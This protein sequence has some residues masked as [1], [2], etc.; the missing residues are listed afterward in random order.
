MPC[1]Q[2][3][4]LRWLDTIFQTT[5]KVPVLCATEWL[6]RMDHTLTLAQEVHYQ[7]S[8][9]T[10]QNMFTKCLCK[11]NSQSLSTTFSEKALYVVNISTTFVFWNTFLANTCGEYVEHTGEAQTPCLLDY[12]CFGTNSVW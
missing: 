4:Y 3:P 6:N 11:S 5:M 10:L 2:V 9:Q 1:V 8:S 7:L 12:N